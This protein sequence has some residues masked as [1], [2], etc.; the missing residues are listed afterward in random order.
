MNAIIQQTTALKYIIALILAVLIASCQASQPKIVTGPEEFGESL[1]QVVGELI[2]E[3]VNNCGE[4]GDIVNKAVGYSIT[5]GESVQW[6]TSGQIGLGGNLNAIVAGLDLNGA[7]AAS[8]GREYQTNRE[9]S[10]SF[11]LPAN[12]GERLRYVIEWQ[13]VWQPGQVT[14]EYQ[15]EPLELEY[16]FRKSI[17]ANIQ[18]KILLDCNTGLPLNESAPTVTETVIP[19]VNPTSTNIPESAPVATATSLPLPTLT[20]APL[21]PTIVPTL[22]S[23]TSRDVQLQVEG[24]G[25][26]P[27][28]Q[29]D[30]IL[31][32]RSALIAAE[33]DAKRQL[34]EWAGGSELESVIIV[35][36]GTLTED[37]IRETIKGRVPPFKRISERY[38]DDTSIGYVTLELTFDS[39]QN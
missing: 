28:N 4:G 23:S 24:V 26:P 36:A 33:L 5:V 22:A 18:D 13:E 15:G 9:V 32:R 10:K 16:Q 17:N 3:D 31:R 39:N 35:E 19:T 34:T 1:N 21:S 37:V 7:I 20:A 38:D 25:K 6:T 30:P 12:P 2:E 11:E 29:T 8:Y 27:T 14:V